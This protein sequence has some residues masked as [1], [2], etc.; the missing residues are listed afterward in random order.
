MVHINNIEYNTKGTGMQWW[1]QWS[2]WAVMASSN[3]NM[4]EEVEVTIGNAAAM[5]IGI[6]EALLRK[7]WV[8]KQTAL[9]SNCQ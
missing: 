6:S 9:W 1:M 2:N 4:E 3:G 5:I 7:K 8:R